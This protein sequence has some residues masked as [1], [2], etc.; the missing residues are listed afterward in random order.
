M[1]GNTRIP[2]TAPVAPAIPKTTKIHPMM[3]N[4]PILAASHQPR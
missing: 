2:K 1:L 4:V 3:A